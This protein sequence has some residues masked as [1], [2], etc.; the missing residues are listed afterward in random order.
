MT[1][2]RRMSTSSFSAKSTA[3]RSGRTLKPTMIAFE[4]EAK[5]TSL[6]EMAPT[7]ER[8]TFNFTFSVLTLG[9]ASRSTSTEPCTSAL[10]T[11]GSSLTSPSRSEEHTSELQSRQY[12]VC[13]LLLEKKKTEKLQFARITQHI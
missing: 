1:V 10:R 4:A 11:I 8:M 5:S 3:L 13:R 6:V 2:W 9:S 7:P 12:L